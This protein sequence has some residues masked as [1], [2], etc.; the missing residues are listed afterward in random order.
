MSTKVTTHPVMQNR[1]VRGIKKGVVG[2][3]LFMMC[4]SFL[5]TFCLLYAFTMTALYTASTVSHIPNSADIKS[6]NMRL[7]NELHKSKEVLNNWIIWSFSEILFF[8]LNL[9]LGG[10]FLLVGKMLAVV[11]V[12]DMMFLRDNGESTMSLVF[13]NM[14]QGM[15]SRY[16]NHPMVQKSVAKTEEFKNVTY[17]KKRLALYNVV[18]DV[19]SRKLRGES[20][21]P[22]EPKPK[23]SID[24]SASMMSDD[25]GNIIRKEREESEE[26]SESE[27]EEDEPV[28]L[29]SAAPLTVS[30]VHITP[31]AQ[32]EDSEQKP[33]ND[34]V[35]KDVD[36]VL[37]TALN[38]LQETAE[39]KNVSAEGKTDDNDQRDDGDD[40]D[41]LDEDY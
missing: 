40:G 29:G 4:T 12:L 35:E 21:L 27:S 13:F 23:E 24:M 34:Q 32:N 14:I 10:I 18:M 31:N 2:V 30:T 37:S 9:F 36:D 15:M 33:S 6:E 19:M 39:F 3:L 11:F 26:E 22:V 41:E 16:S 25:D 20:V 17:P 1:L 28:A 38:E 5:P 8:L 7:Y